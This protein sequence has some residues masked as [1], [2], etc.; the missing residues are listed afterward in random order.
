MNTNNGYFHTIYINFGHN[1]FN[2]H[3]A[4]VYRTSYL[5]SITYTENTKMLNTWFTIMWHSERL[6]LTSICF[7]YLHLSRDVVFS[8]QCWLGQGTQNSDHMF[9]TSKH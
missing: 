9:L 8:H 3:S 2:Y 4:L 5:T 6:L 1:F 7:D